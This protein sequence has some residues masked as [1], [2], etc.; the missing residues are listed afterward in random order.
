[1]EVKC[2]VVGIQPKETE[3]GTCLFLG[4]D[5]TASDCNL[6]AIVSPTSVESE[7]FAA[8]PDLS[9]VPDNGFKSNEQPTDVKSNI[10][11]FDSIFTGEVC[12][13]S[14]HYDWSPTLTIPVQDGE[15]PAVILYSDFLEYCGTYYLDSVVRFSRGQIEAKS[16]IIYGKER[17]LYIH[18]D[19]EDIV[20][21]ESQWS[22]RYKTGTINIYFISKDAGEDN[23]ICDAS[24][25]GI[26]ELKFSAV[27]SDWD[28]KL[29]AIEYLDMRYKAVWSDVLDIGKE[30]LSSSPTGGEMMFTRSYFPHFDEPFQELIYPIG[31]PDAVSLTKRDVDLLLPGTFVN[32]T[33]IDFYIQYLKTRVN[34][35]EQNKFHF[36]NSFF[37]RKLANMDKDPSSAFDGKAA[38]QHVHKWTRKVNLLEKD[39]IFIPVNYNYHWSLIVICYFAKVS[40]YEDTEDNKA[41]QT[42][43]ILHMDSLR[44]NHL[45]LKD[46]IQSYLWEEWKERQKG[47]CENLSSKFRNLKFIPLELPQQQNSYDCGLFLLHYIEL[48]LAEVPSDFSIYKITP[49]SK[50]LQSDWFP[51]AEASMKRVHIERLIK[52]LLKTHSSD[53]TTFS[54]RGAQSSLK[55]P[56]LITDCENDVKYGPLFGCDESSVCEAGQGNEKTSLPAMSKRS[57]RYNRT[58]E[59]Y[60]KEL[61]E[62]TSALETEEIH[63]SPVASEELHKAAESLDGFRKSNRSSNPGFSKNPSNNLASRYPQ[64]RFQVGTTFIDHEYLTE[65]S[66]QHPAKRVRF[67]QHDVRDKPAGCVP[68]YLLA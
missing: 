21:I 17:T 49:S 10:I 65:R 41:V 28:E 29:E 43:C 18:L 48:F 58:S 14:C 45:G 47:T 57:L 38:F 25:S 60:R 33:I 68:E 32:D 27:V 15:T 3:I 36:F 16:K 5:A 26:R 1:M 13:S 51:P 34:V 61:F 63:T 55:Y 67:M 9:H 12:S 56:N 62:Q 20:K 24:V 64:V 59:F 6:D 7:D 31:D 8:T 37:F 53:H 66:E 42:P 44:G 30:N 40:S 19:V 54:G 23:I 35:K 46:L 22:A 4:T 2:S 52:S 11:D 39:F 50:F